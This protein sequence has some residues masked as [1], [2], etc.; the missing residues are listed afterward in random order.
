MHCSDNLPTAGPN[1]TGTV[2]VEQALLTGHAAL[3]DPLTPGMLKDFR[4][5]RLDLIKQGLFAS[6]KVYYALKVI[7]TLGL[8]FT[9]ASVLIG[10]QNTWA[11]CFLGAF[12]LGLGWQQSG[13][14]CHDFCH[15]QVFKNRKLNNAMSY[16]LGNVVQV[17]CICWGE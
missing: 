4:A 6:S 12:M 10:G 13:W 2:S 7:T 14:L 11:S 3:Q 16:F 5:M 15:H 8:I 17:R 1:S 9:A